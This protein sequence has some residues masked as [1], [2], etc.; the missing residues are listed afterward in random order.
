M[1]CPWDARQTHVSL[2]PHLL[3]EP[4]E[5]LESRN[6][7][8][9]CEELGNV[10]LQVVFH[11]RIAAERGD[12]ASFTFDDVADGIVNKLVRRH[13]HVFADV[14]VSG[15]DDVKR[16]WDEIKREENWALALR[17]GMP[18]RGRK[19]RPRLTVCR[20]GSLPCPWPRSCSDGPRERGTGGAFLA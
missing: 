8:A 15:A 14:T 9:F 16:N 12:N 11:A 20:S 18:V 3:E 13:P 6:E 7:Q 19:L 5:A 1:E 4:Y 17:R 10:L 2:A